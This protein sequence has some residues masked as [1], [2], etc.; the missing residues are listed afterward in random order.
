[1]RVRSQAEETHLDNNNQGK[2]KTSFF[3]LAINRVN[4]PIWHFKIQ[5][6]RVYLVSQINVED[7]Q[8]FISNTQN[9]TKIMPKDQNTQLLVKEA[10]D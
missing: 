9:L 10:L 2:S 8:R 7:L 1:M 4:D 6:L 3:K 5:I